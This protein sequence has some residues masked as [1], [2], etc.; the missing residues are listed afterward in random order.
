MTPDSAHHTTTEEIA[1][2]RE[3]VDRLVAA[4]VDKIRRYP[5][6]DSDDLPTE[7]RSSS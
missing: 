5:L 7:E 2:Y 1:R 4:C 6:R 3:T